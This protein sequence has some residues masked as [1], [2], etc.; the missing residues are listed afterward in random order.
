MAHRRIS[1]GALIARIDTLRRRHRE[2]DR[3]IEAEQQRPAPDDTEIKR[4]KQERL[5]LRD[6]ISVTQSVLGGLRTRAG[7]FGNGA[8]AAQ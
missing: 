1:P 3:R 2:L 4:L 7:G 8:G 6:A 5:G